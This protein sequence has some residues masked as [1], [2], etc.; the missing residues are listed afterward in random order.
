MAKKRA[1]RSD[2]SV[3]AA[4]ER[5]HDEVSRAKVTP[6]NEY[7]QSALLTYLEGLRHIHK[8]FCLVASEGKDEVHE[9]LLTRVKSRR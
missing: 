8:A 6:K 3:R 1:R 2:K 4:I 5:M 7:Y 9:Q